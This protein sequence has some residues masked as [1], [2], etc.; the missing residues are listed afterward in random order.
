MPIRRNLIDEAA[1]RGRLQLEALVRDLI[2]ARLSAGLSQASV[3][4]GLGISRSLVGAWEVG[5]IEPAAAQLFAWGSAVG[6]DV[7]LRAFPGGSPLRDAGQLRILARF[8]AT[9]GDRWSWRTEV[10]VTHDPNDRRAL[11]AL[12]VR[13][14]RRAGVE[15]VGRLIDAQ[16]QVR[17]ILL[18][19]E[20]AGLARLV[21]VLGDS[22]HNRAAV[23][24]GRPTLEPAFPCPARRALAALRAGELPPANAV[25]LV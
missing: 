21:L 6:L 5:R 18:K 16:A 17:P 8:R 23:I 19:Q 25:V 2:A 7:S 22:G 13:E 1:R 14:Q 15:A 3:A 12:L 11:D 9:I 20:A 24:A 4:A 10:S